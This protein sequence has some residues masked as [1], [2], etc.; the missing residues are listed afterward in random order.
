MS[1]QL[2][3]KVSGISERHSAILENMV[4]NVMSDTGCSLDIAVSWAVPSKNALANVYGYSPNQLNFGRIPNFSSILTDK[5]PALETAT[6]SDIVF[7]KLTATQVARKA[8]IESKAN[9]RLRRTIRHQT[10]QSTP[11]I[12]QN[13]DS[14]LYFKRD[15]SN[16][17]GKALEQ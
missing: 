11:Y 5:L 6:H 12:F 14:R 9:E 15:S 7:K 16:K 17:I 8:F 10:C 3:Q 2:P 13:G 1:V 4:S